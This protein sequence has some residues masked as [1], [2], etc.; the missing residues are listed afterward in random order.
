MK[1]G[2]I[3]LTVIENICFAHIGL[4]WDNQNYSCAYDALFTILYTIW[5]S[6]ILK[7]SEFF[8]KTSESLSILNNGFNMY[9]KNELTIE[10]ARDNVRYYLHD[11]NNIL[12]P[13]GPVGMNITDLASIL[14][15]PLNPIS[16]TNY[17]CMDCEILT[18]T[19]NKFTYYVNLQRSDLNITNKDSIASILERLLY[20]PTSRRCNNCND[21]L[22]K[23]IS[24]VDPPELLIMHLPYTDVKINTSFKLYNKSYKLK[25]VVFYCNNYYN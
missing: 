5:T 15:R 20:Q 6:D 7:W 4:I 12:F 16:K 23:N 9:H 3:Y 1:H 18:K 14:C 10:N 24:F 21:I 11:Q 19:T 25:C 2:S 8:D 22:Y 13:S 17:E